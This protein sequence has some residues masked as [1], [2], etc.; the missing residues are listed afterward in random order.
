MGGEGQGQ[1]RARAARA[2]RAAGGVGGGGQVQ[3]ASPQG[4]DTLW[5]V[6]VALT[7]AIVGLVVRKVSRVIG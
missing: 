5:Y 6:A 3:R 1:G 2:A 7:L 4:P